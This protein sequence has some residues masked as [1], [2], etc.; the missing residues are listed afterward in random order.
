MGKAP[1]LGQA[2]PHPTWWHVTRLT[3]A[4]RCQARRCAPRGD[5]LALHPPT[6]LLECLRRHPEFL[7]GQQRPE[8]TPLV[9]ERGDGV[10]D[11]VQP[12]IGSRLRKLRCSDDEGEVEF[13]V[14]ESH[15]RWNQ[16]FQYQDA[17]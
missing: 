3:R 14:L 1:T 4:V 8:R 2:E 7:S 9:G 5:F 10:L 17:S 16:K 15:A 11:P 13:N 12:A 6:E